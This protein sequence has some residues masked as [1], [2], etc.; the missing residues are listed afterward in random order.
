MKNLCVAT[1]EGVL[2]IQAIADGT[3]GMQSFETIV[4]IS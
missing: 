2:L 4:H 1:V 3:C